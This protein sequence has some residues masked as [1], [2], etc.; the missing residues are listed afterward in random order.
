MTTKKVNLSVAL[1][2][3]IAALLLP[4]S[5]FAADPQYRG[6]RGNDR[7]RFERRHDRVRD[8]FER[9]HDRFHDRSV[10]ATVGG[11]AGSIEN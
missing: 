7:D 3:L 4:V 1:F 6:R 8:R 11:I 9:R 10:I 5:A 2:A